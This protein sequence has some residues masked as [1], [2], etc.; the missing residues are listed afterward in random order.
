M[1]IDFEKFIE[2]FDQKVSPNE[3]RFVLREVSPNSTA[4]QLDSAEAIQVTR[5]GL[6]HTV[7]TLLKKNQGMTISEA[8][9]AILFE[10]LKVDA[11]GQL[12]APADPEVDAPG[13]KSIILP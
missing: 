7:L 10:G 4:A 2:V 12:I 9:L 13:S 3:M 8:V 1:Y 11:D 5:L 6:L